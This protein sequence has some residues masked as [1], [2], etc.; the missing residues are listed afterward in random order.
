MLDLNSQI[1]NFSTLSGKQQLKDL[2]YEII[3]F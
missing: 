1:T 2:K 3:V